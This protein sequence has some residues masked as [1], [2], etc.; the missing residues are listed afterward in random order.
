[1]LT[2]NEPA[3]SKGCVNS[4]ASKQHVEFFTD[5]TR[6]Y[7]SRNV[8]TF[9]KFCLDSVPFE[10]WGE[11]FT[12]DGS[13]FSEGGEPLTD[14]CITDADRSTF[15]LAPDPHTLESHLTKAKKWVLPRPKGKPHAAAMASVPAAMEELRKARSV[16]ER[17]ISQS[18]GAKLQRID[19][20]SGF[21][22]NKRVSF[23]TTG[24]KSTGSYATGIVRRYSVDNEL[25]LVALDDPSDHPRGKNAMWVNL[26]NKKSGDARCTVL[27]EVKPNLDAELPQYSCWMCETSVLVKAKNGETG[28][29][30]DVV[31]CE[32]GLFCSKCQ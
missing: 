5:R 21:L 16:R 30:E 19:A 28:E 12:G 25:W 8:Q 4:A 15:K 27:E 1:V 13:S 31:E 6:S 23:L 18:E 9:T 3:V 14:A 32:S 11:P 2:P 20:Q 24:K 10:S 7:L 22:L 29:E 17:I 26:K